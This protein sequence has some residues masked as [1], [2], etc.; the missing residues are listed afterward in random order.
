VNMWEILFYSYNSIA[1]KAPLKDL[2]HM[3][4]FQ[5]LNSQII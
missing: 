5:Y 4:Y 1:T 2:T 3:F